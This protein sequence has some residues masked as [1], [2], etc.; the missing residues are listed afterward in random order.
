MTTLIMLLLFIVC[1]FFITCKTTT[2]KNFQRKQNDEFIDNLKLKCTQ[3]R[4]LF[5]PDFLK[6]K[7][8]ISDRDS[9]TAKNELNKVFNFIG[10]RKMDSCYFSSGMIPDGEIEF[11]ENDK[12]ITSMQFVLTDTCN[13]FYT[14]IIKNS[15]K[16]EMT[17]FGKSTLLNLKNKLLIRK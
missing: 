10:D 16:Y 4:I 8:E 7:M 13:G 9:I 17:A 11:Y 12:W 2:N 6:S 15:F 5:Y 3:L 14:D 1:V